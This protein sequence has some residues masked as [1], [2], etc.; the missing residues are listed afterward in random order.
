MRLL[1]AVLAGFFVLVVGFF[2]AAVIAVSALALFVGRR[3]RGTPPAANG[4]GPNTAGVRRVSPAM[5]G[6]VIDVDATEV[7]EP[8]SS[9]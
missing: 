9:R 5:H 7:P 2:T 6:D 3:L 4:T 8:S 1:K